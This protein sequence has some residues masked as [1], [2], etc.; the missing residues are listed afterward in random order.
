MECANGARKHA[1][2]KGAKRAKLRLTALAF[3][4]VRQKDK[5]RRNALTDTKTQ[6]ELHKRN[7]NNTS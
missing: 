1:Q 2:A 3:A 5:M 4:K 6:K 7:N